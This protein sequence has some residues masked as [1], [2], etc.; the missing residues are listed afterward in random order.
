MNSLLNFSMEV[1]TF[2]LIWG[3]MIFTSEF[4]Y[5]L[6]CSYLVLAKHFEIPLLKRLLDLK[7]IIVHFCK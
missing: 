6:H 1:A 2:F 7:C 5:T 4:P 3:E